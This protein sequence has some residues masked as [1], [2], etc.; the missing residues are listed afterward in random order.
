MSLMH[1]TGVC[2]T[3]GLVQVNSL[4]R[5]KT[6]TARC[7]HGVR[8]GHQMTLH[9][10]RPDGMP[11][12]PRKGKPSERVQEPVTQEGVGADP[13]QTDTCSLDFL[14]WVLDKKGWTHKCNGR[15][16]GTRGIIAVV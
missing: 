7:V 15:R 5:V 8:V 1:N 11:R 16:V 6:P 10:E 9:V 3:P 12:V 4:A 2:S 14:K 13:D